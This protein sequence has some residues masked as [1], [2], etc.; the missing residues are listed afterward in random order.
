MVKR[1]LPSIIVT[2]ASGIVGRGFLEGVKEK[3]LIY[4]M[5]RRSQK[6]AGV[7]NHPNIKWIQVDIGDWL[8]LRWVMHNIKREGGADFILHLAGYYD[9]EYTPNPEYERT[10]I[11][12]TKYIL[13]QAKILRIKRFI[14]ASSSAASNFP[15][16]G[17]V[18]NEKSILDADYDYAQSKKIG[19]KIVKEFSQW[20]PCSIVRLAAVFSDY[21]EYGPLYIFLSTWLSKKWNANILGGK[22]ESA[23]PFIHTSDVNK[24]ILSILSKT[25]KL[26]SF[27]IY[28]ASPNVTTSHKELFTV[29]TEF[30]FGEEIKPFFLPKMIA[31]PGVIIRDIIGKLI[32]TRPFE[33]PWMMKYIDLKLTTNSDY[34][35]KELEWKPSARFHILRRLLYLIEK[36]KNDPHEWEIKN[37][38]ALKK[39]VLRPNLLIY[40]LM[41]SKRKEIIKTILD[42]IENA[43]DDGDFAKY[44][45]MQRDNLDREFT[46]F[47]Q[48]LSASVRSSDRM[49]ILDYAREHASYRYKMGFKANE[50]CFVILEFGKLIITELLKEESLKEMSLLIHEK[51]TITIQMIIDETEDSFE[52][53]SLHIEDFKIPDRSEIERRI[54]EMETFYKSPEEK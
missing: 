5:A 42:L 29:V 46:M 50:V 13:E 39:D 37:A 16:E 38:M 17:E 21:C 9:F 51:I 28:L 40:T 6:D 14:F 32:G 24:L 45:Q 49:L 54:R 3:F 36:M 30:Y 53:L 1:K 10:N 12:G 18:L 31:W 52:N 34:T 35:Q 47:L 8:S 15:K 44:K 27:D 43:E 19:E 22:G 20:F 33:R 4:A 7:E 48:L 11:N 2:G 25:R 26:Q 41:V 23:V